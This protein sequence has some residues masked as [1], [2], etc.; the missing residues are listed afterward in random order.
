M[1]RHS[2]LVREL[3]VCLCFLPTRQGHRRIGCGH[4]GRCQAVKRDRWRIGGQGGGRPVSE[5]PEPATWARSTPFSLA[6]RWATGVTFWAMAAGSAVVAAVGCAVAGCAVGMATIGS[7]AAKMWAMMVVTGTVASTP[8][9]MPDK[10]PLAG[11]STSMSILSVCTSR[12]SSPFSTVSPSFFN[13]RIIV[14]SSWAMPN[15]GMITGVG[16]DEC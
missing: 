6:R 5:G 14:P 11:D 13:Q 4:W 1:L 10:T 3:Q 7:F 16:I 9:R 12:S 8:K 15:F 2:T